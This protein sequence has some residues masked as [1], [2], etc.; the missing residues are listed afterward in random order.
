MYTCLTAANWQDSMPNGVK[1]GHFSASHIDFLLFLY[2]SLGI[3]KEI[4]SSNK[5]K[6]YTQLYKSQRLIDNSQHGICQQQQQQQQH[7]I[8]VFPYV[9]MALPILKKSNLKEITKIITT[10]NIN[11]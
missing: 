4:Y 8:T 1:N 11:F 3:R 6:S 2:H 9:Y 7:L 10:Y 5:I